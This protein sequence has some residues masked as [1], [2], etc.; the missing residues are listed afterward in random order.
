MHQLRNCRYYCTYVA[1]ICV[2][3]IEL[4]IQLVA[5][6]CLFYSSHRNYKVTSTHAYAYHHKSWASYWP[7]MRMYIAIQLPYVKVQCTNNNS[8]QYI[9]LHAMQKR[10][11]CI[12]STY[13]FIQTYYAPTTQE[14]RTNY[15]TFT[16]VLRIKIRRLRY[17]LRLRLWR[18]TL[19]YVNFFLAPTVHT[20]MHMNT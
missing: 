11:N 18:N 17:F 16:F 19:R 13:R 1:T 6:T 7:Y 12:H 10:Y 20:Y 9:V 14:L 15:E 8:W 4:R 2:Q 3:T 5:R